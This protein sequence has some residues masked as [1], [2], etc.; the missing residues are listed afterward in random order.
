M[1][2]VVIDEI[3]DDILGW[4]TD[5]AQCYDPVAAEWGKG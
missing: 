1:M 3:P 2:T 4:R 5:G